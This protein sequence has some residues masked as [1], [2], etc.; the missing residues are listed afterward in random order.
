MVDTRL[1]G[2]SHNIALLRSSTAVP[3]LRSSVS[4]QSL[5][6]KD[7]LH[8][9]ATQLLFPVIS[10]FSVVPRPYHQTSKKYKNIRTSH[11][12]KNNLWQSI[13]R[14][15]Y[16]SRNRAASSS[17]EAS[18][19]TTAVETK[20]QCV[21]CFSLLVGFLS[22]SAITAAPRPTAAACSCRGPLDVR[23]HGQQQQ[24]FTARRCG[25]EG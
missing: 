17:C 16:T 8:G 22:G 25:L 9:Q 15:P 24:A 2:P 6:R 4:Q 5:G 18:N 11:V 1:M 21:L 3:L 20:P 13:R 12:L 14:P 7:H 23:L 19:S 10:P